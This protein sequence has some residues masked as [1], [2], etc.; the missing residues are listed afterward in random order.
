M[1][2][3]LPAVL[4]GLLT[5]AEGL[6]DLT[7][8]DGAALVRLHAPKDGIVRERPV[9]IRRR[10]AADGGQCCSGSRLGFLDGGSGVGLRGLCLV[11]AVGGRASV[12]R[13]RRDNL[14]LLLLLLF[15]LFSLVLGMLLSFMLGPL[16]ILDAAFEAGYAAAAAT[17]G[18]ICSVGLLLTASG[19]VCSSNVRWW[20]HH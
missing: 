11:R 16:L 5:L 9:K 2:Y 7:P 4:A 19:F 13:V 1:L 15:M 10:G 12:I 8:R 3:S 18:G 14:L 17:G 6:C 20:Q